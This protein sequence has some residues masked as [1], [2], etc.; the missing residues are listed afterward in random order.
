MNNKPSTINFHRS[1]STVTLNFKLSISKTKDQSQ[2]IKFE[3]L[4][5]EP[6][7]L[8]AQNPK[9]RTMDLKPKT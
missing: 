2:N 5:P 7:T 6:Q 9:G 4:N 1:Y 8:N 3:T